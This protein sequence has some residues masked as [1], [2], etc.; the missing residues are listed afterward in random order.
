MVDDGADY[1]YAYR[2]AGKSRN[3]GKEFALEAGNDD[4]AG[5]WA[6]GQTMWIADK[7]DAKLY[8]YQLANG[9]RAAGKDFNTLR[10]AGN[11]EP[12]GFVGG[13]GRGC[14]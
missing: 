10:A 11:E 7:E 2:L 13:W 3:A 14:G 8:A 5:L 6:D 12:W 1:V 4:P 9:R